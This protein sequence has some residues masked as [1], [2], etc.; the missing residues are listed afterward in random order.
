VPKFK[1]KYDEH[2]ERMSIRLPVKIKNHV[3][4][5]ARKERLTA[6]GVVIAILDEFF[7]N[8]KPAPKWEPGTTG[9]RKA[10]HEKEEDVFA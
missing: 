5:T 4:A 2:T 10:V 7:A 1:A 9:K 3:W 6:T 8:K